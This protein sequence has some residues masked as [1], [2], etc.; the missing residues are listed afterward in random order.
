MEALFKKPSQL[1]GVSEG[2]VEKRVGKIYS[3]NLNLTDLDGRH[4]C[5]I[6]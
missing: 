3:E 4:R 5:S 1:K 2:E 6:E